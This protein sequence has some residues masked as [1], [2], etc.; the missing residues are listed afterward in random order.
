M[1]DLMGTLNELSTQEPQD[2][3]KSNIQFIKSLNNN[4][5]YNE[6]EVA[7]YQSMLETINKEIEEQQVDKENK[8][9][10]IKEFMEKNHKESFEKIE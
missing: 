1:F 6:D 7:W 5:E 3:L 10:E 9:K 4:R 8:Y 2:L